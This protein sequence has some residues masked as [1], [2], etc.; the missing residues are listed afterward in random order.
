MKIVIQHSETDDRTLDMTPDGT[1]VTKPA[2]PW[3][4]RLAAWALGLAGLAV[5]V[6]TI[7]LLLWFTILLL[8]FVLL[9]GVIGYLTLRWYVFRA[10]G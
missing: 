9:A 6:M 2:R 4:D 7:G 3:F 8:P 5:A 1:F 10:R